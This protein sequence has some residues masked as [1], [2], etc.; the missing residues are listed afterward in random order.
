MAILVSI[1]PPSW[2]LTFVLFSASVLFYFGYPKYNYYKCFLHVSWLVKWLSNSSDSDPQLEKFHTVAR[3]T[4]GRTVQSVEYHLTCKLTN[5]PAIIS[6]ILAGDTK[7]SGQRQRTSLLKA[8]AVARASRF[9]A[10]IPHTSK[11]HRCDTKGPWWMPEHAVGCVT[12]EK[13]WAWVI[14]RLCSKPARCLGGRHYLIPQGCSLQIPP[15]VMAWTKSG[16]SSEFLTYQVG[17]RRATKTHGGLPLAANTCMTE[18]LILRWILI[19]SPLFYFI[20]KASVYD[21]PK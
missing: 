6:W 9:L 17:M 15:W 14:F 21:P 13:H 19:F 7:L 2:W 5:W 12:R 3:K 4:L 20:F 1:Y 18:A 16:Q 10:S 8:R 11:S